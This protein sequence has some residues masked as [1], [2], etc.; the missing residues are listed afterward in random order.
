[1]ARLEGQPEYEYEYQLH[2]GMYSD[3]IFRCRR[4]QPPKR[5]VLEDD[6]SSWIYVHT[7]DKID[8]PDTPGAYVLDSE[9]R[10]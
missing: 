6:N 8:D 1:M 3:S 10:K 5:L 7:L 9:K 2:N 4:D